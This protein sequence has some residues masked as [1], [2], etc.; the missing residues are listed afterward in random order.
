VIG[1]A[2]RA[3][4]DAASAQMNDKANSRA[5]RFRVIVPPPIMCFLSLVI[6]ARGSRK[7]QRAR[8]A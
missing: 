2:A 7:G 6:L 5:G 8:Q 3:M 1:S 4:V